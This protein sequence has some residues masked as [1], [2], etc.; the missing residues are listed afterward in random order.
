MSKGKRDT[1]SKETR[2][3]AMAALQKRSGRAE[4]PGVSADELLGEAI[5]WM[6]YY[7]GV[8]EGKTPQEM[9]ERLRE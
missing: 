4:D 8:A 7:K 1:I 9:V 2:R 6:Q 5:T 3:K